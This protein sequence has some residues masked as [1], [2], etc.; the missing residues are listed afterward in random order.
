MFALRPI[1]ATAALLALGLAACQPYPSQEY[2]PRTPPAPPPPIALMGT[3]T[4]SQEVPAKPV[5]GAGTV[6]ATI[7]RQTNVLNYTINYA[8]LTGPLQSAHF[9]GPAPAG[10]NAGVALPIAVTFSPISGSAQLTP[11][12]A[13]DVERGL[14]HLNLHTPTYPDGEIRAQ[15]SVAPP[16]YAPP[17]GVVMMPAPQPVYVQP[18]PGMPGQ[19][20]LVY[21]PPRQ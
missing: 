6:Y 5:A 21:P 17:P 12:M 3:L 15:L 19:P 14:W 11:A 13:A 2:S 7:D 4:G 16:G 18:T 8:G 20:V 10:V 9:H 1:H